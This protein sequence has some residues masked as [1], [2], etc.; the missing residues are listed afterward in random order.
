MR[1]YLE[2]IIFVVL[3]VCSAYVQ[4]VSTQGSERTTSM[5]LVLRNKQLLVLT[6]LAL[7]TLALITFLVG[8]MVLHLSVFNSLFHQA[9][10]GFP[11]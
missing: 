4:C 2:F 8:G 6:I 5:S 11:N 3:F 1:G 10:W 7:V 9:A